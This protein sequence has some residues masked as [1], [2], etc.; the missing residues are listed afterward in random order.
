MEINN[1]QR[2]RSKKGKGKGKSNKKP[3][4]TKCQTYGKKGHMAKDCRFKGKVQRKQFNI[5]T[6]KNPYN[7]IQPTDMRTKRLETLG[8]IKNVIRVKAENVQVYVNYP[9]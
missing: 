7:E 8:V 4:N 1:I 9:N 6:K 5:I 3:E 2:G